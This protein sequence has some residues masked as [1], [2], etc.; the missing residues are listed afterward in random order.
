MNYGIIDVNHNIILPC[1][2][3]D[4]KMGYSITPSLKNSYFSEEK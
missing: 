1:E 3:D 2:Y 4:I